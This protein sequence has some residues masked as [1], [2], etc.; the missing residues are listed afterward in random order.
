MIQTFYIY[1]ASFSELAEMQCWS[2]TTQSEEGPW[3]VSI[4]G[5]WE[6]ATKIRLDLLQTKSGI[7]LSSSSLHLLSYP[8]TEMPEQPKIKALVVCLGTFMDN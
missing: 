8:S 7:N 5:L 2:E 3:W 6:N 4:K 1:L